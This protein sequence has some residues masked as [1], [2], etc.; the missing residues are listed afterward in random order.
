MA[1]GLQSADI[2]VFLDRTAVAEVANR[3]DLAVDTKDWTVVRQLFAESVRLDT[4]WAGESNPIDFSRDGIVDALAT[5]NFD[6]K[7][8]YHV[9]TNEIIEIFGDRARVMA[10]SY[11]WN[12]LSGHTPDVYET[13]GRMTYELNRVGGGWKVS[14]VK[15][16]K[17]R[18]AG[19]PA[20]AAAK[21]TA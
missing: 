20:V 21:R 3:L 17:T 18:E 2:S 10:Q 8:T 9:R 5:S 1:G 6:A 15:H 16:E 7:R 14:S 12:Q 11:G 19:N 4:G 13:W